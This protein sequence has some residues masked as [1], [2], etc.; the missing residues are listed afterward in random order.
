MYSIKESEF[1]LTQNLLQSLFVWLTKCSVF[2]FLVLQSQC[3]IMFSPMVIKFSLWVQEC[4][5][6]RLS[7]PEEEWVLRPETRN[8]AQAIF[9]STQPPEPI[10]Q[11]DRFL[12][13]EAEILGFLSI[14]VAPKN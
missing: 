14:K 12:P 13:S 3:H 8:I 2:S 10:P 1:R 6:L 4:L 5:Y 11:D 7:Q 9:P